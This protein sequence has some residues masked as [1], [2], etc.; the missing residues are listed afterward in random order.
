MITGPVLASRAIYMGLELL[1]FAL[2]LWAL[3]TMSVRNLN[4]LPDIRVGSRL[5]THG[6]YRYIR[7]PMYSALLLVTL[8]LLLDAFSMERLIIWGILA[9]DLWIK[10]NYEEQLLTRH[11]EAYKDYQHRTKRLI[12]FIL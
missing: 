12:P 3:V 8:A 1:G 2:G 10:L 9:G 5:V 7:H 6:P 11:F 4:I